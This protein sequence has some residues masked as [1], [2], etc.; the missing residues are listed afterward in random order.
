MILAVLILTALF[1]VYYDTVGYYIQLGWD[2]MSFSKKRGETVQIDIP[3][4]SGTLSAQLTP[5]PLGTRLENV[6]SALES[7]VAAALGSGSGLGL[8]LQDPHKCSM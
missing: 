7:D 8:G 6:A 3:G 2:K 5:V 4:P 1:A